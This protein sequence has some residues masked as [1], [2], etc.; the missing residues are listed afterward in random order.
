MYVRSEEGKGEE[1]LVDPTDHNAGVF[2]PVLDVAHVLERRAHVPGQQAPAHHPEEREEAI[3]RDVE[4]RLQ[5][6]TAVHDDGNTECCDGEEGGCH[7]LRETVSMHTRL[8]LSWTLWHTSTNVHGVAQWSWL[9][10]YMKK[11]IIAPTT[12]LDTSCTHRSAWKGMRGYCEGA[13][14]ARRSKGFNMV[15]MYIV[16]CQIVE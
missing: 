4:V 8:V 10:W 5:A 12:M 3:D 7:E 2:V 15:A 13:V 6:D 16:S 11:L 1:C 14:F 9:R